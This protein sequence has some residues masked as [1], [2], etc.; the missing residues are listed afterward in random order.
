MPSVKKTEPTSKYSFVPRADQRYVH[1][2]VTS[3]KHKGKPPSVYVN[4]MV[5]SDAVEFTALPGVCTRAFDIRFGCKGLSI[6]HFAKLS[7]DE[8]VEW[9]QL[10]RSNF[11]NLSATAEFSKAEPATCMEDVVDS[12][13]VFLTYAREYCSVELIELTEDILRFLDE[14]RTEVSWSP[15]ELTSVVY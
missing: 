3:A 8:R 9:L 12:T 4:G 6:R 14:T 15:A 11:D 1:D 7:Q 5:R 10:G 13:R 2:R